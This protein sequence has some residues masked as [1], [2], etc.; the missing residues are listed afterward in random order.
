MMNEAKIFSL[1]SGAAYWENE[2]ERKSEGSP[3]YKGFLT[4]EMDYK[5]GEKIKF[6]LWKKNNGTGVEMFSVREVNESKKRLLKFDEKIKS[7]ALR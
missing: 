3:D 2:A 4:L 1:G 5:A 7:L 6:V